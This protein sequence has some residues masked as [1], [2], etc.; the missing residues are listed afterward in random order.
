MT[1]KGADSKGF[2]VLISIQYV[3][4]CVASLVTQIWTAMKA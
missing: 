2:N 1:Q 3:N 4:A